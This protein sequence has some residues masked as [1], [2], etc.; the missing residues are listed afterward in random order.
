MKKGVNCNVRKSGSC[1]LY[2]VYQ[3]FRLSASWE[4]LVF[5]MRLL[6]TARNRSDT[7]Q[8]YVIHSGFPQ[9]EIGAPPRSEGQRSPTWRLFSKLVCK[10][11]D[12]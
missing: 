8:L 2:F 11:K 4:E 5:V 9:G 6:Y 12:I 7:E 10:T 3:I 1:L